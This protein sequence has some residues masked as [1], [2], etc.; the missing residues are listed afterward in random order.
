MAAA[1][2]FR[3]SAQSLGMRAG[4]DANGRQI[5]L[6]PSGQPATPQETE[7]LRQRIQTEPAALVSNPNF[8]NPALGGIERQRFN[9]LK[10]DIK[11]R[12]DL[13]DTELKDL[14]LTEKERDIARS[15]SCELASGDCNPSAEKSYKDGEKVPPKELNSIWS[16]IR[17]AWKD[18]AKKNREYREKMAAQNRSLFGG[19]D[20]AGRLKGLFGLGKPTGEGGGPA[21]AESALAGSAGGLPAPGSYDEAGAVGLSGTEYDAGARPRGAAASDGG[22]G[23]DAGPAGSPGDPAGRGTARKGAVWFMAALGGLAFFLALI[24]LRRR[25]K[26]SIPILLPAAREDEDS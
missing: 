18:T 4:T 24:L 12:P 22:P 5:L 11:S 7:A 16:R 19:R 14:A 6:G 21:G 13:K 2:A 8:F 10:E 15:K 3:E 1:G 17:S 26:K 23:T 20:L 25:E 9:D